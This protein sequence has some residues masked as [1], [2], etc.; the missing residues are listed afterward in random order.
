M[1]CGPCTG[2]SGGS[3]T[4]SRMLVGSSWQLPYLV[5]LRVRS[6]PWSRCSGAPGATHVGLVPGTTGPRRPRRQPGDADAKHF[7]RPSGDRC[8]QAPPGWAGPV[9]PT[10]ALR[11]GAATRRWWAWHRA[12]R[13]DSG[14]QRGSGMGFSPMPASVRVA[15]DSGR[16]L[17][18][19]GRSA[20][21]RTAPPRCSARRVRDG[22]GRPG[23]RASPGNRRDHRSPRAGRTAIRRG[24]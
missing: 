7:P 18:L 19:S 22:R 9:Q 17:P 8:Q 11:R 24:R 2:V 4:R 6:R 1:F 16:G 10:P 3:L 21:G 15:G 13:P 12:G 23:R 14:W 20:Q 5:L